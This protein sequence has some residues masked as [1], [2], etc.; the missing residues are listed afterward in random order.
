M[1][2][3]GKTE[4][5]WEMNIKYL[6]MITMGFPT[7]PSLSF[8]MKEWAKFPFPACST[9]LLPLG[10]IPGF[11]DVTGARAMGFEEGIGR[12]RRIGVGAGRPMPP[13]FK[14]GLG[15]KRDGTEVA[16]VT[17]GRLL[18]MGRLAPGAS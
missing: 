11:A 16:G 8:V 4:C 14:G 5:T 9:M 13:T 18:V 12:L 3:G 7:T 17:V 6:E 10:G 1:L 15:T 2:K